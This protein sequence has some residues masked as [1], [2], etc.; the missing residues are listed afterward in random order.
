VSDYNTGTNT[1]VGI[2]KRY[3][4]ALYPTETGNMVMHV[5]EICNKQ[6]VMTLPRV[7]M[8]NE[9]IP[10]TFLLSRFLGHNKLVSLVWKE[11][12]MM[13]GTLRGVHPLKMK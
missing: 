13:Q 1:K 6:P 2:G 12:F 7:N 3:M 9:Y 8:T 4:A 5:N 10:A 11:G